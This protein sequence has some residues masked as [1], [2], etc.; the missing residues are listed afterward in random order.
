MVNGKLGEKKL[1]CMPTQRY[2]T[3]SGKNE[4]SFFGTLSVDLDG[5]Q[6]WKWNSER[7]IVFQS[8]ILQCTQ[9][10]NNTKHIRERI[11]F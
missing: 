8:V 5:V 2:D 7:V 3:L 6:Y 1:V 11:L 10:V 4:R 9:G